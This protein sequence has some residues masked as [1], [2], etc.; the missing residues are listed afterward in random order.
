MSANQVLILV[1][2]SAMSYVGGSTIWGDSPSAHWIDGNS[3][4]AEGAQNGGPFGSF[5]Y[6][7]QGTSIAFYGNTSPSDK[8]QT[9]SVQI[10]SDSAYQ[11]TYPAPQEYRQWYASPTLSDA[12]HTIVVDNL[13]FIDLDYATVTAGPSTSLN[14][15][16]LIVDDDD[17]E[18]TYAGDWTINTDFFTTGH[19]QPSGLPFQNATHQSNTIGDSLTFQFAGTS[20]AV[21]GVFQWNLIGSIAAS[22]SVDGKSSSR[23][24]SSSTEAPFDDQPN[25]EFFNATGLQPGN[26][27]M[28][29]N[30][31]NVVGT[32]FLRLDYI[33]YEPSFD[34]LA[35]KPNFTS[36]ASS[37]S[38]TPS[39]APATAPVLASNPHHTNVKA[40]A[41][42]VVG[43]LVFLALLAVAFMLWTR[44][45]RRRVANAFQENGIFPSK[46]DVYVPPRPD[47]QI[48]T[49]GSRERQGGGSLDTDA[50][51][52]ATSSIAPST[53]PMSSY[54]P[55]SF[56]SRQAY[57]RA[58]MEEISG[59]TTQLERETAVSDGDREQITALQRRIDL[60]VAENARL[61]NL[62]PPA[63]DDD[64]GT[65]VDDD[66]A[67]ST[68]YSVSSPTMTAMT[69]N[70]SSSKH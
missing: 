16:T 59:L 35:A 17:P 52:W 18:I 4:F 58:R 45:R 31:T 70:T 36:P 7:F 30:V 46:I 64:R 6:T 3:A 15:T 22:F 40:I 49:A 39:A 60:L 1:D 24:F 23:T 13:V 21:R 43:A 63:Y 10:D 32:Q 57:I 67:G 34:T 48:N 5:S 53:A 26:H 29:I 14:G 62:P 2:D 20:V 28:V 44:S 50:T 11:S 65:P 51:L 47:I 33:L 41:G 66:H 19:G 55:S 38:A 68:V 69:P 12:T 8:A 27:A 25:F 9:M 54:N 37:S 56:S 61:A 42:G